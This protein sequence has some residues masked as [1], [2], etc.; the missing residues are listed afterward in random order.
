VRI[1]VKIDTSNLKTRTLREQKRVA[2]SMSQ[3]LNDTALQIQTAQ[4]VNLDKKFTVRKAGFMYRLIK[5]KF[6]SVP[7]DL[8]VAE[9][10]VDNTKQRVLLGLFEDGGEREPA[11]GQNVAVPITGEAARPSFGQL[12]QDVFTFQKLKFKRK[13]GGSGNVLQGQQNTFLVPGVGVFMRTAKKVTELIYTFRRPMKMAKKLGFVD[14][15]RQVF[16]EKFQGNFTNRY[17]SKP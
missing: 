14:I 1:D 11:V 3:A 15:A 17:N 6:A 8:P 10:Y 13:R 7:K 12:V 9:V 2:Y 16:A 4:R 5:I